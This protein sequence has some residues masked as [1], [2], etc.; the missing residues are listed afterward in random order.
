MKQLQE[1]KFQKETTINVL[2]CNCRNNWENPSRDPK[3]SILV[4]GLL[5]KRVLDF[6]LGLMNHPGESITY[7]III[8]YLMWEGMK[9]D[10]EIWVKICPKS[11][12]FEKTTNRTYGNIP[13]YELGVLTWSTTHVELLG[14][15]IVFFKTYDATNINKT[16]TPLT[17]VEPDNY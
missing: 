13:L 5:I 11:P 6:Y 17:A 10:V 1:E 7:S 16:I 15:W 4:P 2:I 9:S 8:Q 12:K 14:I 3:Y